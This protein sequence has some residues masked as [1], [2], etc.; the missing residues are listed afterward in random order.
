VAAGA[1]ALQAA[2]TELALEPLALASEAEALWPALADLPQP[3]PATRVLEMACPPS[4]CLEALA[5]CA[6]ATAGLGDPVL[7]ASP[8][9]GSLRVSLPALADDSLHA[10]LALLRTIARTRGGALRRLPPGSGEPLEQAE[11]PLAALTRRLKQAWDPAGILPSL[12]D[13]RY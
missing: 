8:G 12:K 13:M 9:L 1:G 2:A 11:P 3:G 4:R 6:A 7:T 10:T 5:A